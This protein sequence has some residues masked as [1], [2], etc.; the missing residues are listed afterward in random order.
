V[1]NEDHLPA[2]QSAAAFHAARIAWQ[3]HLPPAD[4]EDIRQDLLV[5]M[6]TRLP[7]FDPDRA[8]ISTFVDLV[9]RH[10]VCAVLRRHR[11]QRRLFGRG[12][13]S[14]DDPTKRGLRET[15]P[16]EGGLAALLGGPCDAHAGADLVSGAP[17][18]ARDANG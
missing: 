15:V 5:E 6:I 11:R 9:A 17:R 8:S 1:I 16:N 4:R 18:K 7:R 12:P 10:A 13:V 3:L 2:L 14:I